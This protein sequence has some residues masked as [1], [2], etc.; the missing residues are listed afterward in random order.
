MKKI[1]RFSIVLY[2]LAFVMSM[3]FMF[4]SPIESQAS[5]DN[6]NI[7]YWD[8]R[9]GV[10]RI[11][12]EWDD[13]NQDS[14][15]DTG[16]WA[17]GDE[18]SRSYDTAGGN[19]VPWATATYKGAVTKVK[20]VSST[21]TLE[22]G[23]KSGNKIRPAT[24]REWF[25]D[26]TK[27]TTVEGFDNLDL[28]YTKQMDRMFYNCTSLKLTTDNMTE[29][30]Q[31]DTGNVKNMNRMFYGASIADLSED[32]LSTFSQWRTECGVPDRFKTDDATFKEYIGFGGETVTDRIYWGYDSEN[33][34]FY[35]GTS[36][37][38]V[39]KPGVKANL[40]VYGSAMSL[41]KNYKSQAT[42]IEIVGEDKI[43]LR[44]GTSL[45]NGL[46]S[47]KKIN[48]IE[49]LDTSHIT[50]IATS[51]NTKG[52]VQMFYGMNA[53]E[54][55]DIS[56]FN[57]S[58][59]T[60]MSRMF[61]GCSSLKTLDVTG[62]DT[63]NVTKLS[64]MFKDCS[65]LTELDVTGFDTSNVTEIEGMFTG[66]RSLTELGVSDWDLSGVHSINELFLSCANLK[67]LDVS[68]WNTSNFQIMTSAFN[69]C[70]RLETLDVSKW[71][72][73]NAGTDGRTG[74]FQFMFANCFSLKELDLSG[75][76]I[77]EYVSFSSDMISGTPAEK[78]TLP[79]IR[80]EIQIQLADG[81]T[82]YWDTNFKEDVEGFVDINH[83]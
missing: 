30:S 31:L 62:L 28:E 47:V 56:G 80:T 73:R 36:K 39:T 58:S 35:V 11:G 48:G 29:L 1:V 67:T 57:T 7:I 76:T 82:K 50:G 52:M 9:D 18:N 74:C 10:L 72:T 32:D 37:D 25:I 77:N 16:Y 71:D 40:I 68:K 66:C 21:T 64:H 24:T 19:A 83:N 53:L 3:P 20:F 14:L 78:I 51:A 75:F 2:F 8:Y 27:L 33:K 34:I 54:E 49:K 42:S 38:S 5:T 6:P 17:S 41:N 26:F 60:S 12:D 45:F 4:I 15:N 46:S 13:V 44:D 63:S 43:Y 81:S 55:L 59:V 70:R 79:K 22:D 61:E 65:S 23:T 69:G